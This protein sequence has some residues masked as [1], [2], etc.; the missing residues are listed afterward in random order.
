MKN[1]GFP[2]VV[3]FLALLVAGSSREGQRS[4]DKGTGGT[5][6]SDE[7]R[8]AWTYRSKEYD[9]SLQFP[10]A[11]W[12]ERTKKRFIADFWSHGSK[13]SP[14]L[15]GITSVKK[16]T[17]EEFRA[18][19]PQFKAYAEKGG[20]LLVEPTFQEGETGSG[21]PYV[22]AALCE[23]GDGERQYFYVA[24][25]A[26]WLADKG[27]TVSTMFEGQ[28]QMR[29]YLF[30]VSFMVR[31][32]SGVVRPLLP[33]TAATSFLR[34]GVH[35]QTRCSPARI[36]PPSCPAPSKCAQS[37]SRRQLCNAPADAARSAQ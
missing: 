26:V 23:K 28:G 13:G 33:P 5:P 35:T 11:G 19:I 30:S 22:Y 17:R 36:P 27:I 37:E 3:L 12:K 34:F 25:A 18:S 31:R 14:M 2:W 4:E 20:N 7:R 10:S 21:N 6:T 29:R 9:F 8:D 24:T 16:Q 1:G 15:A 32:L